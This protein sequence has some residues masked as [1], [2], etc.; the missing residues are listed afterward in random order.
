MRMKPCTTAGLRQMV[1]ESQGV[2]KSSKRNP[3]LGH[4]RQAESGGLHRSGCQLQPWELWDRGQASKTERKGKP[5]I[6]NVSFRS[7][8]KTQRLWPDT[9]M[10]R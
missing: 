10:R 7:R 9:P 3:A 5:L 8:S 1:V 6:R 2:M 4:A